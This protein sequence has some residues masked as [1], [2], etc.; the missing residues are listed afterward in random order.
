M[1]GGL[2]CPAEQ[3]A[4]RRVFRVDRSLLSRALASAAA[5]RV[6]DGGALQQE[7][8]HVERWLATGK[9]ACSWVGHV[10]DGFSWSPLGPGGT[11]GPIRFI[12]RAAL[13]PLR[14]CLGSGCVPRGTVACC[15]G[16]SLCRSVRRVLV[17]WRSGRC[18]G[19]FHVEQALLCRARALAVAASVRGGSPFH[20][21][22]F[23]VERCRAVTLAAGSWV[24]HVVGGRMRS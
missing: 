9:P 14:L 18:R 3:A 4:L 16:G 19:V 8:F 21:G 24:G 5:A 20:L 13:V 2:C 7:V 15:L 22:V 1:I 12:H 23:H 17:A 10:I 11:W 6:W